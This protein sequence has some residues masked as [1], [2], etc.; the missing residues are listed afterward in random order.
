MTEQSLTDRLLAQVLVQLM[1]EASQKE[2][3]VALGKAGLSPAE[4]GALLDTSAA[5]ISQQLYEARTTKG[6]KGKKKATG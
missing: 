1:R 3:A 2:K 5:T 6:A 4:I